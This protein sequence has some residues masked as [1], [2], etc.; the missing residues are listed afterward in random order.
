MPNNVKSK[1]KLSVKFISLISVVTLLIV[2][3]IAAASI[4]LSSSLL[5]QQSD[6]FNNQLTV[7][8]QAEQTL[9]KE[10]LIHKGELVAEIL[11]SSAGDLMLN[12]EYEILDVLAENAQKDEDISFVA[13]RDE[14]NKYLTPR[15]AKIGGTHLIEKPIT[16]LGEVIGYVDIGMNFDSVA[17]SVDEVKARV[18]AMSAEIDQQKQ[19][20]LGQVSQLTTVIAVIGLL[21]LCL[22]VYILFNRIILWP[23]LGFA[24]AMKKV[25]KENDYSIR[26]EKQSHDELGELIDG[27]NN[28]LGQ[29]QERDSRLK[30][31]VTDLQEAKEIAESASRSKSQFLANMSH[32]IRTPMNGVLGMTEM[33]LDS[34]LTVEQHRFAETVRSSGEALLTIINDILDFSKIEAGKMSLERLDFDLRQV[35]EDVAHLLATRA[36]AKGLELAVLIPESVPT[37]LCGDPGRLRQ[38]LTNLLGNAIK[39]T[40]QGEVVITVSCLKQGDGRTMLKFSVSDTGIGLSEEERKAIFKAFT[41]ADG[42]TTRKYGGT[43]LGLIISKQLVEM[44]AGEIVCESTKGRGSTFWFTADFSISNRGDQLESSTNAELKG[45]RGLVVDDNATNRRILEHQM[46]SWGMQHNSVE[47]GP[48]GLHRLREAA[49]GE[50]PYDLVILDMHMPEMD[51]LEVARQIKADV[52]LANLP[53]VML[54]SVG[55]R[56]DAQLARNSG[57]TAYLT[58]PVR[59][60]DLYNCLAAVMADSDSGVD[61][62]FLTRFSVSEQQSLFRGHVLL[63]EDNLVNQQVAMGLLRK[64]GC[65][66]DLAGNGREAVNAVS[67]VPYDIVFM[68]CQMPVLDGYE[69]TAEIRKMERSEEQHLPIIA[70]TANAM[71]GDRE[72]CLNAGMDDY[73]SKPFKQ[74]QIVNVLRKWLTEV[75]PSEEESPA[76]SQV[77]VTEPLTGQVDSSPT[78]PAA[79]NTQEVKEVISQHALNNIRS[80]SDG[81][82]EKIIDLYLQE[83]P[84]QLQTLKTAI[85]DDDVESVQKVSHSLKSSSANLGATGLSELCKQLE[86]NARQKSLLKASDLFAEIESEYVEVEQALGMEIS[87]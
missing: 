24:K 79:E 15:P 66:V 28:M 38:I 55:L 74:E 47:S 81:M 19:E 8:Q 41:Q 54:T 52:T 80:L 43:G 53:L 9:L 49:D 10:G 13:F 6:S 65:Q 35:V 50:S 82:L 21:L 75:E 17:R 7:V 51:G 46:E 26:A 70:L 16:P 48:I 59:Q 62:R 30:T 29:I 83:S 2:V 64:L 42:S 68:D 23:I 60:V 71:E 44:M 67:T 61:P 57:I 76:E 5:S 31:A 12:Y 11:V 77:E 73:L 22:S 69:A 40:E 36:H 78:Q 3:I 86:M 87:S 72:K 20:K 37:A 39:F 58:K 34:D 14:N 1:H 45:L 33:L 84:K 18:A 25:S 56:G 32:E 4:Y 27:F 85:D 63:V